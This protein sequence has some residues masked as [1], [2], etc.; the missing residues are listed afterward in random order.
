M[1]SLG[2]AQIVTYAKDEEAAD[3]GDVL[4]RGELSIC[5]AEIALLGTSAFAGNLFGRHIYEG[6][7]GCSKI[8]VEERDGE[9]A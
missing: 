2:Q 7:R 4:G 1:I 9:W 3:N 6:G 8:T 5:G